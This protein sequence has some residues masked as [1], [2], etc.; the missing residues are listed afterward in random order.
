MG[1]EL[2]D[3][4]ELDVE[5]EYVVKYKAKITSCACCLFGREQTDVCQ[6]LVGYNC[7]ISDNRITMKDEEW[8]VP[9][10]CPLRRKQHCIVLEIVKENKVKE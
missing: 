2:F 10:T 7:T 4:D 5:E 3:P 9:K 1:N 6:D 8:T